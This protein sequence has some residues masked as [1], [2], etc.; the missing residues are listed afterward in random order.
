VFAAPVLI[1]KQRE[2][3]LTQK[4][5]QN[6]ILTHPTSFADVTRIIYNHSQSFLQ[7]NFEGKLIKPSLTVVEVDVCFK[8]N[9]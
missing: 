7:I 6:A 4:Y 5:A 1:P 9:T 8:P 3:L 2:I